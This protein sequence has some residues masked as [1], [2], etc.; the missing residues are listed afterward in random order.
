MKEGK[1]L[2][3]IKT[4]IPRQQF[5]VP[6]QAAIG[7]KI[8]AR[9]NIKSMGKN[10]LSKCYGGDISRKRKLLENKKQVKLK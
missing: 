8:V 5:E 6:V 10:V 2:S 9:T 4:L 3:K 7:Q 1:R